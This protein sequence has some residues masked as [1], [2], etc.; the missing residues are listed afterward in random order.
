MLIPKPELMDPMFICP[1]T[2]RTAARLKVMGEKGLFYTD[3]LEVAGDVRSVLPV[4]FGVVMCSA[5][6]PFLSI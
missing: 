2:L 6:L 5:V 1:W 4:I 3:I